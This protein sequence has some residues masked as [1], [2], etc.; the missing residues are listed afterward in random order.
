MLASA[1]AT[2]VEYPPMTDMEL[3]MRALQDRF[4]REQMAWTRAPAH[5][6]RTVGGFQFIT[7]QRQDGPDEL[8][9][10]LLTE[11]EL[12]ALLL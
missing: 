3:R 11:A 12:D 1:I 6:R 5:R 2:P 7:V 4:G 10:H 8:S 9:M